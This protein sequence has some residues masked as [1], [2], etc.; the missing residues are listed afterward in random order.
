MASGALY[1]AYQWTPPRASERLFP[2]VPLAFATVASIVAINCAVFVAWK[3]PLPL[4]WRVLN[5]YFVSVPGLPY[6]A[7]MLGSAF[8]HQ[9]L[10][11]LGCNMFALYIFGTS[12]C[13]QIGSGPFL[14]LYLSGGVVSSLASLTWNVAKQRFN[15]VSL[16]ASGAIATLV[17]VYAYINPD[18]ELYIIFLPFLA[19]KAKVFVSVMA[20]V[21]TLGIVRGWAV[22]DHVAHLSG[23]AWGVAGAY[24]MMWEVQR[25]ADKKRKELS[26][27]F[28]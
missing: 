27:W 15:V 17:G 9:T 2:T 18:A 8:S 11:H 1:Y 10:T 20:A 16:G 21:E 19:L 14:G 23:L 6:A 24:A 5:R 12:L 26:R 7:S 13:E 28:K 25:R 4:T 3:I 22:F